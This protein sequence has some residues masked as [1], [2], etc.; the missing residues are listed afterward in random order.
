MCAGKSAVVEDIEH[1][2]KRHRT[3]EAHIS[4]FVQTYGWSD[5]LPLVKSM[6]QVDVVSEHAEVF[7]VDDDEEDFGV[8]NV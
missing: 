3:D 5:N 6:C 2:L 8:H 1:R 4:L 7:E